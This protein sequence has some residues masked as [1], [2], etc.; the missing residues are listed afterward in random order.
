MYDERGYLSFCDSYCDCRLPCLDRSPSPHD[1]INLT[2]LPPAI[3]ERPLAACGAAVPPVSD[4]NAIQNCRQPSM[5]VLVPW[6]LN[7]AVMTARTQDRSAPRVSD[8]PKF[9]VCGIGKR[10]TKQVAPVVVWRK[11]TRGSGFL[12]CSIACPDS[13]KKVLFAHSTYMPPRVLASQGTDDDQTWESVRST[14][15]RT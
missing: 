13:E 2:E 7:L 9:Q 4:N 15:E 8:S 5:N 1:T 14:T 11:R 6:C 10:K 12:L 3:N